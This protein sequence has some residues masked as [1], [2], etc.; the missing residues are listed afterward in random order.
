MKYRNVL[1]GKIKTPA[2]ILKIS[3]ISILFIYAINIE[4]DILVSYSISNTG[5]NQISVPLFII[6][7]FSYF[8]I[9]AKYLMIGLILLIPDIIDDPYLTKQIYL[10]NKN[11]KELFI[12]TVKLIALYILTFLIWFILL[13]IVFSLFQAKLF[14]F[15]W[16]NQLMSKIYATVPSNQQTLLN[17]PKT[18]TNYPFSIAFLLIMIRVFIGFLSISLFS[19]YIA[20]KK[21]IR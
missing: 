15:S 4:L 3:L 7:I 17:I 18:A 19:F 1:L 10:V 8:E 16:P 11:R 21:N 13:T 20:L 12:N 5:E 14:N 6:H 2:V 9:Y